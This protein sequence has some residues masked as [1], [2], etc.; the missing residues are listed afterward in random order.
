MVCRAH[1]WTR[2]IFSQGCQ[3]AT[4]V[5]TMCI[6]CLRKAMGML[7][8]ATMKDTIPHIRISAEFYELRPTSEPP[9]GAPFPNVRTKSQSPIGR[10]VD[11]WLR[12]MYG[13]HVSFNKCGTGPKRAFC[14]P[15]TCSR[16]HSRRSTFAR[17]CLSLRVLFNYMG[18][19]APPVPEPVS[20]WHLH[21][22]LLFNLRQVGTCTYQSLGCGSNKCAKNG[23]L[24]NGAQN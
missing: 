11:G 4:S 1:S 3:K 22:S 19:V 20:G 12:P 15:P 13:I 5:H 10:H 2:C 8:S 24:V 6:F 9:K 17:P 14:H 23:T 16:L 18:A 21:L 7:E